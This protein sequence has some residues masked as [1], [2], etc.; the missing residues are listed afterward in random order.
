[1]ESN[2]FKKPAIDW[3]GEIKELLSKIEG[4]LPDIATARP[5]LKQLR[6]LFELQLLH[7]QALKTN[8]PFTYLNRVIPA[9]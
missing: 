2:P 5:E 3:N 9:P 4:K 8:F 1:M 7:A 6:N